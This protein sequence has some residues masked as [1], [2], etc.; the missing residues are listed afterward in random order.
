VREGRVAEDQ[1]VMAA[2]LRAALGL[3]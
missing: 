1:Q 2:R 3:G